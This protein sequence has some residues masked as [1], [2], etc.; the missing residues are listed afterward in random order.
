MRGQAWP[1]WD[2]PF[3][4][5]TTC[6]CC[7]KLLMRTT[8]F[9]LFTTQRDKE[10]WW[11]PPLSLPLN[12]FQLLNGLVGT[13]LNFTHDGV[14]NFIS[15]TH[16]VCAYFET[17]DVWIFDAFIYSN[18]LSMNRANLFLFLCFLFFQDGSK[19]VC[20][21]IFIISW[22][23]EAGLDAFTSCSFKKS[24]RMNVSWMAVCCFSSALLSILRL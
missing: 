24:P 11:P 16:S 9:S 1:L 12:S 15:V 20:L 14:L 22:T 18:S 3:S 13:R 6:S 2:V 17:V 23:F 8:G 4:L 7:M 19:C 5:R 10:L 21:F